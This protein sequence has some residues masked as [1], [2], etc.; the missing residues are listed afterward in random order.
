MTCWL[1]WETTPLDAVPRRYVINSQETLEDE[2]LIDP[3]KG[4]DLW[5]LGPNGYHRAFAGTAS[6]DH[7][8]EVSVCYDLTEPALLLTLT[9]HSD[10][11]LT[12]MLDN[13]VYLGNQSELTLTPRQERKERIACTKQAGWYDFTIHSDAG[14]MRRYAGRIETGKHSVSDPMMGNVK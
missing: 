11:S 8:M 9:N 2:W 13:R 14:L 10:N 4:Y 3:D 5:L 7:Y 12:L 6:L 1:I